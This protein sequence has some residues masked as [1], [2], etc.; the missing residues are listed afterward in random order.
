M[1][2]V[3]IKKVISCSSED[4]LFPASNILKGDTWKCKNEGEGQA[5]VLLQLEE[6][7]IIDGLEI[8]NAGAAFI[9]VQVGRKGT[10]PDQM[11]ALL[12]A[13]S[14]MLVNEARLGENIGRERVFWFHD[15]REDLVDEKWDIVKVVLTQPFNKSLRYG[16]SMF[17][18]YGIQQPSLGAFKLMAESK[19]NSAPG[20]KDASA[21]N[22][23]MDI[24][25]FGN[26]SEKFKRNVVDFLHEHS[27][28]A[29]SIQFNVSASSVRL[30]KNQSRAT[31]KQTKSVWRY[32]KK[33]KLEAVN[34]A[35]KF[36]IN[37]TAAKFEV[38]SST[39]RNWLK[40][41]K[42]VTGS[43]KTKVYQ[44]DFTLK[45][46]ILKFARSNTKKETCKHFGL[47][48]RTLSEWLFRE[49]ASKQVQIETIEGQDS[50]DEMED[51]IEGETSKWRVNPLHS[52]DESIESIGDNENFK[53]EKMVLQAKWDEELQVIE[54]KY[55]KKM[56][57]LEKKYNSHMNNKKVGNT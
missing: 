43:S 18:M 45:K 31:K 53:L 29:T 11:K 49:K 12:V 1:A 46:S 13:S 36:S 7:S 54:R 51:E 17:G 26:Y 6:T 8:G 42:V 2:P 37:D 10:D 48:M 20:K 52:E 47:P 16:L 9:E 57:E 28:I 21:P 23:E 55:K 50:H 22:E 32:S 33:F 4:P 56:E 41:A 35:Q 44:Y 14:F 30:W 24:G 19:Q 15:L 38:H 3:K 5:W 39:V 40:A 34:Y 25:E 27:V